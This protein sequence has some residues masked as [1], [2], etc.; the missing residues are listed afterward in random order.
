MKKII[1]MFTAMLLLPFFAERTPGCSC[2]HHISLCEKYNNASAVFVGTVLD[3]STI[4]SGQYEYGGF[5][6]AKRT[7]VFKDN[8]IRLSVEKV[9]KGVKGKNI[10]ILTNAS[11]SMCGYRFEPGKRYLIY[12]GL[13]DNQYFT[14]E[15]SGTKL[16]SKASEDLDY[17]LELPGSATKTRISGT[18]YRERSHQTL[19]GIKVVIAGENKRYEVFTNSDGVYKVLG[20]PAG[21]YLFWA[22]LPDN[23]ITLDRYVQ[24]PVGG[25]VTEDIEARPVD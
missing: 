22:V 14:E 19:S 7:I 16:Y 24:I 13:I 15:C 10:K 17:I 20:L 25:C 9:F 6:E 8:V 5:G 21:E 2:L 18:V 4:I 1:L 11:D 3:V 12:A 23:R